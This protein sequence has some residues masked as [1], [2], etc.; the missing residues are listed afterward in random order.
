MYLSGH[1]TSE[2]EESLLPQQ[3]P[4]DSLNT[5]RRSQWR[6]S[7]YSFSF[8]AFIW[9]CVTFLKP[10]F[11]GSPS[12]TPEDPEKPA[13]PPRTPHSTAYLDGVRGVA[14]LIV[15]ILH[16]SSM[17]FPSVNLGWG[18]K[19]AKSFWLLPFI[20]I[21]HSGAAMVAVFFVV[22]GFVLSHRFVQR[23]HRGQYAELFSGL[24]S[25]TFRRAIRLF[26]PAFVSSALA[27]ICVSLGI[28]SVPEKVDGKPFENS[29]TA[30][31]EYLDME[32]NPWTWAFDLTGFYNPQLWS[33]AVEFRGSMI[34]F[35]LIVG[36][37]KTRTVVRLAVEGLLMIHCF[38]H[39][40]W[41]VGL[42]IAGMSLAELEAILQKPKNPWARML[43]NA[44]LILTMVLGLF[45]CGYPR[46]HNTETPGYIWSKYVWPFTA[47][48]RRFWMAI[49]AMLFVGSLASLPFIQSVF[50]TRPTRYL[51]R[52]SFALYLVHGLG[53]RTIGEW[54]LHTCWAHIGK[55]DFW[56]YATSFIVSTVLYFPIVIWASD[57]FWRGIDVPS[58]N[59]AK[60]LEKRCAAPESVR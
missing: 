9:Q 24:T 52:I 23:M 30:Y 19:D 5:S 43:V 49:G 41:D 53:N 38:T 21:V 56:P 17:S 27:F 13:C 60:W 10:S 28:I 11:L 3:Q 42:F 12:H 14:S 48:R 20:R 32:S 50:L 45:F 59:L 2:D 18:Y 47:Y 57:I 4:D 29:L 33:I 58:T 54:L 37:A 6:D 31:L 16:W 55:E 25:L 51:G 8:Q 22:S 1:P 36:L 46:D 35:L 7:L 15:F 34:V 40:R 44:L 39:K 26:L